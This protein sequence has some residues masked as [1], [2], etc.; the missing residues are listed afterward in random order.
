MKARSASVANHFFSAP[1]RS[2]EFRHTIFE[3]TWSLACPLLLRRRPQNECHH[4][5]DAP[6]APWLLLRG[7]PALLSRAATAFDSEGRGLADDA[8][9]TAAKL[10]KFFSAADAST[11][12][13]SC[14]APV[15]LLAGCVLILLTSLA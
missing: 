13:P 8:P 11:Q 3:T 15:L 9:P 5:N 6:C 4:A 1:L 7:T 14:P 10:I 12:P 2:E